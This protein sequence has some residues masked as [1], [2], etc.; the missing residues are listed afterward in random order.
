MF[1]IMVKVL[2]KVFLWCCRN[3]LQLSDLEWI[4]GKGNM[5]DA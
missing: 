2:D 4:D 1:K 5:E 3:Y